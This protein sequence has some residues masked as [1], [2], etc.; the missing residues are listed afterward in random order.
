MDLRAV[1]TEL[2]HAMGL[3]RGKLPDDQIQDMM[4]LAKAG[5][6]GIAFENLCTQL[7]E[8]DVIVDE[9][10]LESLRNIGKSMNIDTRYCERLGS[11]HL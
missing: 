8:Y 1:E 9:E 10:T 5:E 6:P 11:L 4:D 2:A 7:Y 3:F